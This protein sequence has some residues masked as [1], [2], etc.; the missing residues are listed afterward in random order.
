MNESEKAPIRK[1]KFRT[2]R[3]R[4]SLRLSDVL[5]PVDGRELA[6]A[7]AHVG[8]SIQPGIPPARA[9]VRVSFAGEI[10]RKNGITIDGNSD[11]GILGVTAKSYDSAM[12]VYEELRAIL[13]NE[14]KINIEERSRFFEIIAEYKFDSVK[15]PLASISKAFGGTRTLKDIS[16]IFSHKTSMYSLRLVSKGKVPNQEEWLDITIEPDLIKPDST[17]NIAVIFRSSQKKIVEQFGKELETRLSKA[18][19]TIES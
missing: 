2:L 4:F 15:N 16:D 7:L 18:I 11:R 8:Y 1:G 10:A 3:F 5:F 13:S 9:R 19:D 6:D 17:Y 12:A 14:L